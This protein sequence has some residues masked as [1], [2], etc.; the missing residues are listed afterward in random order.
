MSNFVWVLD[1][2]LFYFP[3]IKL[4]YPQSA[5]LSFVW[6][7]YMPLSESVAGRFYDGFHLTTPLSTQ[8]SYYNNNK[9]HSKPY[10]SPQSNTRKFITVQCSSTGRADQIVVSLCVA[11]IAFITLIEGAQPVRNYLSRVI[12][13]KKVIHD[14][15]LISYLDHSHCL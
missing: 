8:S 9:F 15:P 11:D 4:F 13:W 6:Q 10:H 1:S 3:P 14:Y 5:A 12:Y 7:Y 2:L